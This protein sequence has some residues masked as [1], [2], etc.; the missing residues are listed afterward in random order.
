MSEGLLG[1]IGVAVF[2]FIVF[3]WCVAEEYF[4]QKAKRKYDKQMAKYDTWKKWTNSIWTT[5]EGEYKPK[6]TLC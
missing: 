2:F 6:H 4:K 5:S 3:V 1:L